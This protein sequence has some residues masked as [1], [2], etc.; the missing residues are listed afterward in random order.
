MSSIHI[1]FTRLAINILKYI[2]MFSN[3]KE[4]GQL[5]L[6]QLKI[7]KNATNEKD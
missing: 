2:D 5:R 6:K 4:S 1:G 3:F 7:I